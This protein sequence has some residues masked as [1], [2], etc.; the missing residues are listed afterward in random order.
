MKEDEKRSDIIIH[1]LLSFLIY[2]LIIAVILFL[3]YTNIKS[4]Y[5]NK[6]YN[7]AVNY[8]ETENYKKALDILE[9]L[10]NLYDKNEIDTLIEEC[11]IN[12][13]YIKA[14]DYMTNKK[15][16][17]AVEAYE[18]L[19]DFKDSKELLK[20]AYYQY[21]IQL[22]NLE[23]YTKAKHMFMALND[24]KESDLYL[25]RA[26][27]H[28]ENDSKGVV[29]REATELFEKGNYKE[30]MIYFERLGSYKDSKEM[31]EKCK[32]YIK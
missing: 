4:Q 19:D 27:M 32:S 6:N 26:S 30:A 3:V 2:G 29:Y 20:E 17:K 7:E 22:F 23:M 9:R 13:L 16:D 18:E 25:A 12:I 15:Y 5:Y 1:K 14:N 31:Y 10:D 8:I 21:G 11:E 28:A 24:Y